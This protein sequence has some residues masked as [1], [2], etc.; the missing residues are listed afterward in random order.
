MAVAHVLVLP[1]PSQGHIN[2]M[3]E[4]AKR[5]AAKGPAVTVVVTHHILASVGEPRDALGPVHLAAIS[6]GHDAG[7]FPSAASLE[8]YL[9][10]LGDVGS[11]TLADLI[12]DRP[13][14][15]LVYDTYA[16]WAVPVARRRGLPAVAFST[17][18]CT[19]SAIY[20]YVGGG[21]L[22]VP[23]EGEEGTAAAAAAEMAALGLPEMGR[24][25]FPSFALKDGSYP[26]LA[27]FALS[28]F[29]DLGE[30]DWVLFNSFDELESKVLTRL[31]RHFHARAIGPC[32]PLAP[33][34]AGGTY[35]MNLLATDEDTCM[36]WLDAKP[37]ASVVYVAFGSFASLPPEQMAQLAQALLS[38]N[39]HFLWVVRASEEETLPPQ[40]A[41]RL[42][43][44]GG[45]EKGLVVKWSPQVRV[46]AHGAVGCFVTH[47]GWNSTLEAI[48]FGVP[49]VAMGLWTD[50]LTNAKHM[51]SAWGVGV[52]AA[53]ERRDRRGRIV[54]AE[55][56]E[57]CVREVMEGEEIRRNARRW[58]AA[59]E[60]AAGRGGSSDVSLDEFVGFLSAM[61]GG[62]TGR[63]D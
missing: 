19:V 45:S 25:E 3:L 36:K 21:M 12:D 9:A 29:A 59:A 15:C 46:L 37:P 6:D 23:A 27:A 40:F 58:R 35:G 62:E 57:R 22:R 44:D 10:A 13:F 18:S 20:Y 4:F 63:R 7:G 43:E 41:E 39:H 56:I 8:A 42:K 2:P 33:T 1:Y 61:K 5:L 16:P 55:E 52:R 38:C 48:G 28:Q 17:Q 53:A 14:T 11:R 60:R 51:E 50:Q 24:S 47:C 54:R 34:E 32:V 30:E 31:N 49:T 26:T